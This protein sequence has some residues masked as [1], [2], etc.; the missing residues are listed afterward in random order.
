MPLQ[1]RNTPDRFGA[2]AKTLHWL[3]ALLIAILIPLGIYANGLPYDSSSELLHK[4]RMF[5]L[6]KTLGV[7]VFALALLRITWAALNPHP[8]ALHPDRRLETLA[9]QTVHGLLYGSILLVPLS[10]WLHHASTS[11]FAPILWPFGQ[12]LPLVPKSQPL[13]EF[14]AGLHIVLERVLVL[15]LALHIAGALKHHLIDR[16][17]TLRRMTWGLAAKSTPIATRA[18]PSKALPW[19][20]AGAVW[21]AALVAGQALGVFH[22]DAP[23]IAQ[24]PPTAAISAPQTAPSGWAVQEGTIAITI[25]QFGAAVPGA[26]TDWSAAIDY[27][28]ATDQGRARVQIATGSLQLGSLTSEALAPDFLAPDRFPQ[29]RFDADLANGTATGQLTLRGKTIPLSYPYLLDIK[30]GLASVSA[31]ITLDR[32]SF[33]IGNSIDDPAALGF[34]VTIDI[35]LTALRRP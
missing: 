18:Q 34:D 16:D 5:S 32:R 22:T 31:R 3:V 8:R 27:D 13:A 14:T 24:Q 7:L 11:G 1:L 33:D 15:A 28:P 25:Q 6:H 4:A 30:D 23:Q 26:F 10:G 35:A 17:A 20:L 21:I 29:A 2:I 12:D 19:L 9:A